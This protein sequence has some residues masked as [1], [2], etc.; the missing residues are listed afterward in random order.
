M[1][2]GRPVE[3][4]E[5]RYEITGIP[6]IVAPQPLGM[7]NWHPMA[8]SQDTGLVYLPGH[9]SLRPPTPRPKEFKLNLEGWNTGIGFSAGAASRPSLP[10]QCGKQESYLLA[11]DPVTG[12]EGSLAHPERRLR[13][14]RRPRHVG[15]PDLLR[16]PQGR[17]QRLRR[18]APARSSGPRRRRPASSP[19]P[20]TFTVDGEQQ[21]AILVGARGLPDRPDPHQSLQR[22]QLAHPRLPRSAASASLADRMPARSS[23]GAQVKVKIDPPLLTAN[24]ETVAS[25]E[26]AVRPPTAPSATAPPPC[27]APALDRA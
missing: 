16:Q 5:A 10:A 8:F 11:W 4:P 12:T 27:R 14:L 22:Q 20:A 21:V 9:S 2:T 1:T 24:N 23:T 26:Q 18:H 25:G 17:V 3:I 19:L 15:Q 13:R 7:H 6:A